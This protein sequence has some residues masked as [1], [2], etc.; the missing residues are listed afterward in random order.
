MGNP[1]FYMCKNECSD[2]L[3]SNNTADLCHL[4]HVTWFIYK[5][6]GS[7]FSRMLQ[8]KMALIGQEVSEKISFSFN[9]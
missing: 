1:A 5:N 7:P 6:Y 2:Q 4:G 8:K 3:C 9:M